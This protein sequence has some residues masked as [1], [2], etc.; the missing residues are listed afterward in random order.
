MCCN[1]RGGQERNALSGS[2]PIGLQVIKD[3][4]TYGDLGDPRGMFCTC[5]TF[6][7][8]PQYRRPWG[9]T[10]RLWGVS[11]VSCMGANEWMGRAFSGGTT[12]RP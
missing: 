5:R 7:G 10:L 3:I 2:H 12:A 11:G 8:L 6:L 9:R 1:W 4:R